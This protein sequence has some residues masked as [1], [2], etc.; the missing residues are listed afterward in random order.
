[1]V[2]VVAL[3]VIVA[4]MIG[5]AISSML[6]SRADVN[7]AN[8]DYSPPPPSENPPPLPSV[9]SAK[10]ATDLVTNNDLYAQAIPIPTR[11][12]AGQIDLIAAS[13]PAV[14]EHLNELVGCLMRVWDQPVTDAGYEMPRPRV[15]VYT[16]Q[17][18]TKC[19]KSLDRNAFYC[20]GDQAIYYAKNYAE[21]L[22]PRVANSRFVAEDV[23]SHEFGH[24]LQA[25]TGVMNAATGLASMQEERSGSM[26]LYR[27]LEMQAD[28]FSGQFLRS[29]A[30]S[31]G[32]TEKDLGDIAYDAYTSGDDVLSGDPDIDDAHGMG[33]NRQY[34]VE[35][36]LASTQIAACNTFVASAEITR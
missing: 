13:A 30:V 16:T 9:T 26:A 5:I 12:E 3:G 33:K 4:A 32:M 35:L 14:E 21:R 10:Q 36:G 23:I 19:G 34:W 11:C 22:P 8:E 1:M 15:T 6:G 29:V 28:C 27:R 7:Y 31:T 2:L 18:T 20:P 17:I 25:R 24:A